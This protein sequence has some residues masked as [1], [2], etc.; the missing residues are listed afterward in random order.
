MMTLTDGNSPS[1]LRRRITELKNRID[2]ERSELKTTMHELRDQLTP[3]TVARQVVGSFLNKDRSTDI[4]K[5]QLTG[6]AW[7]V[8][9]R[10]LTNVLVRDPRAAFLIKNV[11]P[12]AIHYAPQIWEKASRSLPNRANFYN[13]LRKRVI[14]LRA[15]VRE[16]EEDAAWFI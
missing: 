11:A 13:M 3:G 16:V 15:R 1:K 5:D 8:P 10:L 6:L 9:L 12:V 7:Q 14:K 4:L 2:V